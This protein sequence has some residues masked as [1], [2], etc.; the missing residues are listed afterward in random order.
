MDCFHVSTELFFESTAKLYDQKCSVAYRLPAKF[1]KSLSAI[2]PTDVE[3]V[4]DSIRI[5]DMFIKGYLATITPCEAVTLLSVLIDEAAVQICGMKDTELRAEWCPVIKMVSGIVTVIKGTIC[6]SPTKTASEI[7]SDI[8]TFN[9]CQAVKFTSAELKALSF[10]VCKINSP[11]ASIVCRYLNLIIACLE[12]V[13]TFVC[14][15]D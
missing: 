15:Q 10:E 11:T 5:T 9:I 12:P 6:T 4:L 8:E 3:G 13:K 2:E 14:N 7:K 1:L